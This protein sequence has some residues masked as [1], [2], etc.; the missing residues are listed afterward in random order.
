MDGIKGLSDKLLASVRE[1]LKTNQHLPRNEDL[2]KIA[3][4]EEMKKLSKKQLA[5]VMAAKD[6]GSDTAEEL[7][8]KQKKIASLSGDKNKIDSSDLAKL[9]KKI[10]PFRDAAATGNPRDFARE[11]KEEE[12][13]VDE[14]TVPSPN[15]DDEGYYTHKQIHGKNAVSK[16]DWK[17]GIRKSK[18]SDKQVKMATGIPHDKRYAGGNMTGAVSAIEKI[19]KNLS[20][21]PRVAASL[22][23]ANEETDAPTNYD[24]N[25]A[26]DPKKHHV[27]SLTNKSPYSSITQYFHA[28][29]GKDALRKSH[30]IDPYGDPKIAH[31]KPGTPEHN[32]YV[33]AHAAS[34]ASRKSMDVE[35][36]KALVARHG[37]KHKGKPLNPKAIHE[38]QVD[39]VLGKGATA[40]DYI[41]DFVNS[42]NPKFDGKSKKERIRMA[43]GAAYAARNDDADDTDDV[44]E[45]SLAKEFDGK[46]RS[47]PEWGTAKKSQAKINSIIRGRDEDKEMRAYNKAQRL[48]RN[49]LPKKEEVESVDEES[50][51]HWRYG[52]S[53]GSKEFA[54][55]IPGYKDLGNLHS[56]Y[57]HGD[58]HRLISKQNP[59]LEHHEVS[60]IVNSDGDKNSKQ[61]V[62]H[63]GKT[64]THH[65]VNQGRRLVR[66]H[67]PEPDLKDDVNYTDSSIDEASKKKAL[68]FRQKGNIFRMGNKTVRAFAS[69]KSRS[70]HTLLGISQRKRRMGQKINAE[71]EE[72]EM[73]V[74]EPAGPP[75][76]EHQLRKSV[77]LRGMHPVAF[78]NGETHKVPSHVA[79][80]ATSMI[81]DTPIQHGKR[82]AFI[83]KLNASP[84]SFY[85]HIGLKKPQA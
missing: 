26:F 76:V 64:Y 48:K 38:E 45:A 32:D 61:K 85:K 15:E 34:S 66:F 52:G 18:A 67:Y 77:S 14:A 4:V 47:G 74:V 54:V 29:E 1:V 21:H 31:H 59:N 65:V 46:L 17:K 6:S 35:T 70:L 37:I 56:Y 27:F 44:D 39:E 62:E 51:N 63:K 42:K 5:G 25:D 30:R 41:H 55:T 8:P 9:R 82:E 36:I 10:K 13:Q 58:L 71:L 2:L 19:R 80:H 22:K 57:H 75:S 50:P 12:E 60:A 16:D 7:S 11:E 79:Q 49:L 23:A 68:G 73:D 84:E 69:K 40:A 83:K 28:E 72:K 3:S 78:E 43:L 24:N 20:K 81:Q 33:K 53:V